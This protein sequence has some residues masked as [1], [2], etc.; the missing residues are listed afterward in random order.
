MEFFKR[1]RLKYRNWKSSARQNSR[2]HE[3]TKQ[4]ERERVKRK[5]EQNLQITNIKDKPE[6]QSSKK[7]QFCHLVLGCCK[8]N[9]GFSMLNFA[10]LIL[11][12]FLNKCS[13]VIHHFN[14]HFSLYVFY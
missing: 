12:T 14:V 9:C 3:G 6:V 5:R 1:W 13:S 4:S 11:D 2:N 7:S 10:V 8:S